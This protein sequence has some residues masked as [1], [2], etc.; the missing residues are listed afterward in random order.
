MAERDPS[1][2]VVVTHFSPGLETR[3]TNFSTDLLTAYFQANVS[4]LILDTKPALWVYG[5]NHFGND[6]HIGNTRVV[7]NQLG[8]PQEGGRIPPF[9]AGRLIE[10]L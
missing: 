7:S 8:Y 1:K 9:D 6:L 4:G 5:H 10:L 2:V 3:N